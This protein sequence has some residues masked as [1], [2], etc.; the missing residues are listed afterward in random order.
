MALLLCAS[1][2]W[3]G[4]L[5]FRSKTSEVKDIGLVVTILDSL[6]DTNGKLD[7]IVLAEIPMLVR[8]ISSVAQETLLTVC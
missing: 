5:I 3:I 1:S 7:S 8:R 4:N 6:L 2:L